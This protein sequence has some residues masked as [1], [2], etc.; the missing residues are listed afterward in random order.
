MDNLLNKITLGDSLELIKQIPSQSIDMVNID[1]P[2]FT[3]LPDNKANPKIATRKNLTIRK[4]Q[5]A[6]AELNNDITI[7]DYID[8]L[9]RVSK[10]INWIIWFDYRHQMLTYLKAFEKHGL[11]Y[12]MLPW[13]KI[14]PSPMTMVYSRDC[15]YRFYVY[16]NSPVDYLKKNM[17]DRRTVTRQYTNSGG[18]NKDFLATNH[19][20]P[21][22][23]SI[24]QKDIKKHSQKGDLI[25]DIFS[26]SGTTAY[27][28]KVLD[29]NFIAF[30]LNEK[31]YK[32]SVEILETIG[33]QNQF[34][35]G[36]DD[37]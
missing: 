29:R 32:S 33:N 18:F 34:N 24:T 3:N 25:L 28:C 5:I 9:I 13:E 2:Y 14:N 22:P 4:S 1:P 6:I 21:K 8:E 23:L 27:S 11:Q 19:P 36:D 37:E 12:Y 7:D 17:D 20:T 16:K 35:F 26:G 10:T 15:E 31:F 30:E